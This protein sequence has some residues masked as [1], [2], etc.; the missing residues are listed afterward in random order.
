M[1][2]WLNAA[3]AAVPSCLAAPRVQHHCLS[4]LEADFHSPPLCGC[5]KCVHDALRLLNAFRCHGKVV[6]QHEQCDQEVLC[7][8]IRLWRAVQPVICLP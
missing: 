8:T 6:G 5:L 1:P 4:L 2:R 3:T 7:V